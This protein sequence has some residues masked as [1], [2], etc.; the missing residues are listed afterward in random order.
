MVTERILRL[1]LKMP[2]FEVMVTGE[3]CEEFR[4]AGPWIESRLFDKAGCRRTYDVIEYTNGY[5]RHRPRFIT[6]FD[7]FTLSD[8]VVHR[9]YSNG[10]VVRLENPVWVI[11]HTKVLDI[12]NWPIDKWR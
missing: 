2:P 3:K 9:E 11:R 1:T 4:E 7:G 5:G 10:F 8:G 6:D 12:Q